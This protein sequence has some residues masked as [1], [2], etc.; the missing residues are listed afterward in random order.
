MPRGGRSSS[1]ERTSCSACDDARTDRMPTSR[2]MRW[3]RLGFPNW[4]PPNA[5][6]STPVVDAAARGPA[7]VSERVPVSEPVEG[8]RPASTSV[9]QPVDGEF[10]ERDPAGGSVT[11]QYPAEGPIADSDPVDGPPA[12]P[13]WRRRRWLVILGGAIA[14][15]ALIAAGRVDVAA[16]C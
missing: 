7:A 9:P 14:A 8:P 11:G 2:E 15:L 4:K 6:S 10:A 1:R 13:W 5:D 3:P 16:A 12:A